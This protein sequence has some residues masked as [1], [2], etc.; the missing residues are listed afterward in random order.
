MSR[1][2]LTPPPF[3]KPPTWYLPNSSAFAAGTLRLT[4]LVHIGRHDARYLGVKICLLFVGQHCI[5]LLMVLVGFQFGVPPKRGGN[6][7]TRP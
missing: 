5:H 2:F 4:L 1:F 7:G 3:L 6:D